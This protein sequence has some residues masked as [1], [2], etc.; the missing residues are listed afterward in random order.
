[1]TVVEQVIAAL[2]NL[3]DEQQAIVLD[4]VEFLRYKQQESISSQ[5]EGDRTQPNRNQ[6][7]EIL[8][9]VAGCMQN[10]PADLSTNPVYMEEFGQ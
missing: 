6:M 8:K 10:A 7:R 2:T 9:Q 3:P 4:F 5:P 1:M